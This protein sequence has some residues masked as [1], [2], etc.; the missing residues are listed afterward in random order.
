MSTKLVCKCPP[1]ILVVWSVF[2]YTMRHVAVFNTQ[3]MT[4]SV[5]EKTRGWLPP[6]QSSCVNK[7]LSDLGGMEFI[8]KTFQYECSNDHHWDL[9]TNKNTEQIPHAHQHVWTIYLKMWKREVSVSRDHTVQ[10]LQ[11]KSLRRLQ[12]QAHLK[13]SEC[14][15]G[16]LGGCGPRK[17]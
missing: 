5:S 13:Q 14:Q 11:R 10:H 12:K 6:C 15:P 3:K 16:L 17:S 4:G 9:V 8:T 1:E 2:K 7:D